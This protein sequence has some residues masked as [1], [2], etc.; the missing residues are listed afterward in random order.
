MQSSFLCCFVKRNDKGQ[1]KE[2]TLF[3]QTFQKGIFFE[4][5]KSNN[6][7]GLCSPGVDPV[8]LH[9]ERFKFTRSTTSFYF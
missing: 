4:K 1:Q 3:F 9:P 2:K 6:K 8:L 7:A 5:H